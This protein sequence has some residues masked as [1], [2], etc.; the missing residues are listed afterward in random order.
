MSDRILD[1]PTHGRHPWNGESCCSACGRTWKFTEGPDAVLPPTFPMC[2]CGERLL[3]NDDDH[4]GEVEFTAVA[5][6]ARCYEV[7]K[8][9]VP[10]ELLLAVNE[11]WEAPAFEQVDLED[12]RE[13]S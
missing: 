3:P 12:R 10:R 7:Y 4:V 6:C 11:R 5:I 9:V 2:T 13:D 1:C 8:P